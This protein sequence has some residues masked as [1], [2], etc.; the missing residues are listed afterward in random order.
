MVKRPKK[1]SNAGAHPGKNIA[2]RFERGI[3]E[4]ANHEKFLG[5]SESNAFADELRQMLMEV[6]LVNIVPEKGIEL[7]AK[8]YRTADAIVGNAD[9]S[10]GEIGAVYKNDACNL[11]VRYAANCPGKEAVAQSVLDLYMADQYG[12]CETLIEK[13]SEFLTAEH[14]RHLVDVFWANAGKEE[15][16]S[17]KRHCYY[18]I[19]SFARQLKDPKLYIQARKASCGELGVAANIDISRVYLESG[20][21]QTALEWLLKIPADEEFE[22]GER[23]ALLLAVY[24]ALNMKKEQ[25]AVAWRIFRRYRSKETFETILSKIGLDNKERILK[26]ETA[27]ILSLGI[28]NL[29]DV[30]FLLEMGETTSAERLVLTNALQLDGS[31]YYSILPLA[32]I[33]EKQKKYL[34]SSILYR[35]LLDSIL[36]RGISKYYH[37]GVRYYKILD[38][39]NIKVEHWQGFPTHIEYVEKL[40]ILHIRKSSFW[41]RLHEDKEGKKKFVW[42]NI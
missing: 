13:S 36:E 20:D 35:S 3:Q 4:L 34:T 31:E 1:P 11:F 33:F 28:L 40:K 42:S 8:F 23:D 27:L 7:I 37:H 30:N 10:D 9:D 38:R 17:N 24:E 16:D 22:Q 5:W 2:A 39:L 6:S 26:E 29:T 18:A 15:K 41:S 12:V 32:Q 21:P 25:I 14:L 19:E